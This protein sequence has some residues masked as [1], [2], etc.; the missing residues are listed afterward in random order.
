MIERGDDLLILRQASALNYVLIF[1][2]LPFN[3]AVPTPSG[4]WARPTPEATRP[5]LSRL[6]ECQRPASAEGMSVFATD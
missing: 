6:A 3:A 2:Q 1:M 5:R 4:F